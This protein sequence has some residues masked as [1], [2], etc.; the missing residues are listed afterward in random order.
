MLLMEYIAPYT[1]CIPVL[2]SAIT[3]KKSILDVMKCVASAIPDDCQK[4]LVTVTIGI[5]ED[6]ELTWDDLQTLFENLHKAADYCDPDGGFWLQE[7]APYASCTASFMDDEHIRNFIKCV[8][9]TLDVK[10]VQDAALTLTDILKDRKLTIIDAH[11][12]MGRLSKAKNS[13]DPN[14]EFFLKEISQY[15]K[16]AVSFYEDFDVLK[17]AKCVSDSLDNE[18]IK[19]IVDPVV[20]LLSKSIKD[21][22]IIDAQDFIAN[23]NVAKNQCDPSRKSDLRTVK[24][25]GNFNNQGYDQLW[26]KPRTKFR[27]IFG[28]YVS[29]KTEIRMRQCRGNK[30]MW[31]GMAIPWNPTWHWFTVN[32][33]RMENSI[34]T[35]FQKGDDIMKPE[36]SCGGKV[37]LPAVTVQGHWLDSNGRHNF[38]NQR[39]DWM[40]ILGPITTKVKDVHVKQCRNQLKL[41][42]GIVQVY[43]SGDGAAVAWR[44]DGN[45]PG[46]WD[47]GDKLILPSQSC[48]YLNSQRPCAQPGARQQIRNGYYFNKM[49]EN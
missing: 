20:A 18:C 28:N 42:E 23:V 33:K 24:V 14:G 29:N 45:V 21:L 35:H 2:Q 16:C 12:F 4:L 25:N 9:D 31:E 48:S 5:G 13:C 44:K 41:W 8:T 7:I 3:G 43:R 38:W 49:C 37:T 30:E 34:Y 11:T 27:S 47:Y 32:V 6:V 40:D 1:V 15:G 36:R 22:T 17:L 26:I 19:K 46:Q 39:T 10:C